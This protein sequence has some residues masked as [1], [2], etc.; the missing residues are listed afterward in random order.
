[1]QAKS[2]IDKEER[3][4]KKNAMMGLALMKEIYGLFT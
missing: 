4:R 1:M 2:N 3:R